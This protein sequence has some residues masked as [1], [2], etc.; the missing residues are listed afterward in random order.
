[1]D[2]KNSQQQ[3]PSPLLFFHTVQG[4]QQTSLIKAAVELDV[5]TAIDEGAHSAAELGA[6]RDASERGMRILCDSLTILGFLTKSGQQ[7]HLTPDS[8]IFLSKR[9]PAYIGG[10]I[11][12]LV[13]PALVEGY[14]KA[15]AAVR[16]GGTALGKEGVLTPDNPF[17]TEFARSMGALA[18]L[19]AEN[20]AKI[21]NAPAG[22]P[23]KVLDIAAGHGFYGISIAKQNPNATV[24]ALDWPNVLAVAKENAE[25]EGVA[26]RFSTKPGDAFGTDFGSEYDVILLTNILHHFDIP[27]CEKLLAK[28]NAALKPEGRAAIFDFVPNED[29]ISPPEAAMF[30][31]T[32]LCMTP[33]GDAYTFSQYQQMLAKTGFRSPEIHT[34]MPAFSQLIIAT[35]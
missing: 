29:R 14:Q 16:K 32:M 4:F 13:T 18:R 24:V 1:M 11:N 19:P 7:Y 23:W 28:V 2:P 31:M 34:V 10:S 27:T 25:K 5:F 30:P 9:S 12:F 3:P 15:A 8:A 20:I 35:R 21:L 26:S 22:H 33:N 17:W 6:K